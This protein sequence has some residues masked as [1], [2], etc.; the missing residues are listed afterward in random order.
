MRPLIEHSEWLFG[1][2]KAT[3]LLAAWA[4]MAYY[5]R[6]NLAF[7]RKA[8]IVGSIVYAFVWLVWFVGSH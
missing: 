5:A 2:V 7:V 4:V 6:V 8:A 1:L 3:T